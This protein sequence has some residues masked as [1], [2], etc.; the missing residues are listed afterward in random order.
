MPGK[1]VK[2]SQAIKNSPYDIRIGIVLPDFIVGCA[3]QEKKNNRLHNLRDCSFVHSLVCECLCYISIYPFSWMYT[4]N[5]YACLSLCFVNCHP[6]FCMPAHFSCSCIYK[7]IC[8]SLCLSVF[9]TVLSREKEIFIVFFLFS[10]FVFYAVLLG[11]D[12]RVT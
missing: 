9:F 4:V 8:F 10:L 2:S 3:L 12:K 1:H 11:I 6:L 5:I 7:S